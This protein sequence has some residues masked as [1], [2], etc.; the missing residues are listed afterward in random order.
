M[1]TG[2]IVVLTGVTD[3]V[4]D[5]VTVAKWSNGHSYLGDIT[6]SGCMTGT[7]IATFCGGASLAANALRSEDAVE[8]GKLVRGD[9]FL[10][11]IGGY[12]AINHYSGFF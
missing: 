2:C 3:W 11:A 10:A 9:M 8:D 7:T 1:I 5:G 6:G 4:S 12:V